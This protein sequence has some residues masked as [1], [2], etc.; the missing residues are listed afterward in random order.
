[1]FQIYLALLTEDNT[2]RISG[3]TGFLIHTNPT[4]LKLP[5]EDVEY[6]FEVIIPYFV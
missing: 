4:I 2:W 5:A 6:Y 3:S 1:M